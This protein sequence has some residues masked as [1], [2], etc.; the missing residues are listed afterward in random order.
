MLR[1]IEYASAV[2]VVSVL[3]RC[4]HSLLDCLVIFMVLALHVV[5]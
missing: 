5:H 1:E 2:E 3:C 4:V